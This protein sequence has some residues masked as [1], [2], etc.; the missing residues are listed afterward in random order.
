ML[1]SPDAAHYRK[2]NISLQHGILILEVLILERIPPQGG[3]QGRHLAN[4][5]ENK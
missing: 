5:D 4:V 2:F 1:T 3:Q